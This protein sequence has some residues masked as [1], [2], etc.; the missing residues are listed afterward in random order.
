MFRRK[1]H[2]YFP[3]GER[4]DQVDFLPSGRAVTAS[5]LFVCWWALIET[6]LDFA[7]TDSDFALIATIGT[8]LIVL[9]FGLAVVLEMRIARPVLCFLCATTL[10]A[11]APTIAIRSDETLVRPAISIIDCATKLLFL[12][13]VFFSSAKSQRR[14]DGIETNTRLLLIPVSPLSEVR[15][16]LPAKTDS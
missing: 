15:I 10:L 13:C 12:G 11:L 6:A 7:L 14:G 8:R 16:T 5:A 3:Q 1:S 9:L 4:S 2:G